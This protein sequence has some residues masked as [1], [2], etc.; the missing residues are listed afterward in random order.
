MDPSGGPLKAALFALV[1]TAATAD[2]APHLLRAQV[3]TADSAALAHDLTHAPRECVGQLSA[4][5]IAGRALFRSPGLLGGPAAR[6]GLS[7]N[8]CHSNG[9]V[10]A[11]FLLPEL[12]NRAGAADVT[13]EWA[14]KVRGDGMMNPRPIPDL[15]GVGSRTTHGQHG[16]PSLEHFVHSV[17]EEEFQGPM[18][19][20]QGFNDLIAYLRALDATHCGGGIRIT[21]TG[22]A[23][24]VRQAVDAAQSA[25]A[26]TASALLLAA[27]DATGRIVERLPHD[28]FA[29]QRAALEALSRELGGMRYSLDVRVALE[30]GAAGWKARFDAV[31]AQV[32]P[33]ERQTYFNETT[34]RMALRRR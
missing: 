27:Q 12:T 15:V 6:V 21:L 26:P 4:Q 33:N 7:C 22:T 19:P 13:S 28:R 14:S 24:D 8:A 31:I 32:A 25:D 29:N 9:R 34:L 3:W 2:T 10:N 5:A 1:L 30:T 11:T 20:T 17:I 23:D 16:D 18:P